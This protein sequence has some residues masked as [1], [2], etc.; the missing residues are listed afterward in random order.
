MTEF[1]AAF[2]VFLATHLAPTRPP[3]RRRLVLG[4]GERAFQMAYT[5]ISLA[6]LS[7]LVVAAQRAPAVPL[8]PPA[9][10]QWYVALA[11][12]PL[13]FVLVAIGLA[14]P[15]PHSVRIHPVPPGWRPHGVLRWVR[16][17]LLA[18]LALWA[19]AHVPPNGELALV[20]LFG[21]L[22]IFAIAGMP[23]LER[24]RRREA[25]ATARAGREAVTAY[26]DRPRQLAAA[27][28]G[29]LAFAGLL[30]AHRRLFGVDPLAPL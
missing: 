25:G 30:L 2:V 18:G 20:L 15:T 10:W 26:D 14:V 17:P 16:H 4:L 27:V 7:W 5:A 24:R 9:L 22:A 11:V 21:G 8:W 6:T 12:M 19:A 1:A 13:A 23:A 3:M 29:L 28:V